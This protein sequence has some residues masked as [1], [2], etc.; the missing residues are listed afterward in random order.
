MRHSDAKAIFIL[1]LRS[2]FGFTDSE[3]ESELFGRSSLLEIK[4]L[5]PPIQHPEFNLICKA[6]SRAAAL[7]LLLAVTL[8]LAE[9]ITALHFMS[10]EWHVT[11]SGGILHKD[12]TIG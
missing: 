7:D 10:C 6:V 8:V 4:R 9:T 12:V 1:L 11:F 3:Y 2:L 5:V